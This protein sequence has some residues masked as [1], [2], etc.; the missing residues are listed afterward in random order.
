MRKVLF[1]A[2]LLSLYATF[3]FAG[4]TQEKTATTSGGKLIIDAFVQT[5]GEYPEVGPDLNKLT[6]LLEEKFNV[7][8]D[9]IVAPDEGLE[10]KKSVLLASGDYPS[11]FYHG[12]FSRPEQQK[13]GTLGV[14]SPLNDLIKQYG[15]N[16]QKV[17]SDDPVYGKGITAPDGKIYAMA[18]AEICYHCMY[19]PKYWINTVWLDNLGL[20][21]PET[22]E[23]FED[24]LVAF[25]TRDPNGNGK[26][27]E[28]PLSG[29]VNTWWCEVPDFLL[30]SFIYSDARHFLYVENGRID[31][32]AAKPAFREGLRYINGLYDKGLID[33]QAFTQNE[34]QFKVIANNP[35]GVILGAFSGGHLGMGPD[36]GMGSATYDPG[37]T[38]IQ[39]QVMPPLKG[40]SGRR[41]AIY[42]PPAF[43]EANF[44]ITNVA[45][46]EIA[47]RAIEIQDWFYTLEG[48]IVA[49]FGPR[50]YQWDWPEDGALGMRGKPAIF[51]TYFDRADP[52]MTPTFEPPFYLTIDTFIGWAQV[53]DMTLPTG[54]ERFL[55]VATDVYA[56]YKPKEVVPGAFWMDDDVAD[57]YAQYR[58]EF[59][60]YIKQNMATFI[61]GQKS[62]DADWDAYVKGLNAIGLSQYL[63][64]LQDAYDASK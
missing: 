41:Q 6:A 12:R 55:T 33:P 2:L 10:E 5:N 42:A 14:L 45:S 58:T 47:Q 16:I 62:L 38:W 7:E 21:M 57:M 8:F 53:Q 11:V 59:E 23:E 61:T 18:G 54:Y 48:G 32:A 39:Y 63:K 49:M 9:F 44:A 13:Y 56:Q 1:V 35:D 52:A 28:I 3:V 26:A 40:P 29:A 4:A 17:I 24:V 15:P 36:I 50:G 34:E 46:D 60:S 31:M 22:V 20:D 19:T 43:E 27:D 64:I 51:Q 30:S 25:K 37:A